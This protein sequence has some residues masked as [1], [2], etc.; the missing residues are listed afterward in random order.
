MGDMGDNSNNRIIIVVIWAIRDL[1]K[2][3][4]CAVYSPQNILWQHGQGGSDFKHR[5]DNGMIIWW[6]STFGIMQHLHHMQSQHLVSG[7]DEWEFDLLMFLSI[8]LTKISGSFSYCP[9]EIYDNSKFKI[10][11]NKSRITETGP[12][13]QDKILLMLGRDQVENPFWSIAEDLYLGEW[14]IW[15]LSP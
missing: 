4:N 8:R 9:R 15:L 10:W 2:I 5:Y 14:I 12:A 3:F 7:W 1:L 6:D 11:V 13:E